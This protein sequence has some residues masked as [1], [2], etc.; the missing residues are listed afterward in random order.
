MDETTSTLLKVIEDRDTAIEALSD[1]LEGY[2]LI[3]AAVQRIRC[4][5]LILVLGHLHLGHVTVCFCT[6]NLP[7]KILD[8]R[9]FDSS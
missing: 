7:T 3:I 6:P 2:L 4:F 8:F 9:G 5:D 1:M